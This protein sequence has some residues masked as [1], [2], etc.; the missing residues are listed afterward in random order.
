[1]QTDTD[2]G[3]TETQGECHVKTEDWTEAA[4]S[5]GIPR[6]PAHCQK[7]GRRKE[8]FLHRTGG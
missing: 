1:M 2:R 8:G 3:K 5:Q 4:P 7:P 6:L